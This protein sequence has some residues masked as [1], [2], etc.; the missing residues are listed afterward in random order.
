MFW[1]YR[2]DLE[3]SNP[4]CDI[5]SSVGSRNQVALLISFFGFI[6]I[7][8]YIFFFRFFS[9]LGYYRILS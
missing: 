6:Y 5:Y 9:H 4:S 1:N 3:K 8:I 7:H 2:G